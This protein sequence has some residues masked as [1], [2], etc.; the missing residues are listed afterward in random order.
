ML[1]IRTRVIILEYNR[2]P[3]FGIAWVRIEVL[4]S[5][6]WGYA[7]FGKSDNAR[8]MQCSTLININHRNY[9]AIFNKMNRFYDCYCSISLGMCC[10]HVL[11]LS[12]SIWSI[13]NS[14][15]L[16]W[17]SIHLN[18]SSFIFDSTNEDCQIGLKNA[19]Q[20]LL[21]M[22]SNLEICATNSQSD[23]WSGRVPLLH[24]EIKMESNNMVYV[25]ARVNSHD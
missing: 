16:C 23:G 14:I 3:Q 24:I 4:W 8:K 18:T 20:G 1:K 21:L 5:L 25:C 9:D 7:I 13:W 6:F 2:I 22:K 10:L 15:V 19:I 12:I 11:R 17:T